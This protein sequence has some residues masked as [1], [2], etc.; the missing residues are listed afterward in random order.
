MLFSLTSLKIKIQKCVPCVPTHLN[1][2]NRGYRYCTGILI[3]KY[4]HIG[5]CT[6]I[7]SILKLCVIFTVHIVIFRFIY[8][9]KQAKK[10]LLDD[11]FFTV[12]VYMKSTEPQKL[13]TKK[14]G[15][16]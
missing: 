12:T 3:Y 11:V 13:K 15:L 16:E 14:F 6:F 8:V 9:Y 5:V 7:T 4:V 2:S 1:D 10:F